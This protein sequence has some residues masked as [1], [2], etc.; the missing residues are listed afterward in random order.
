MNLLV[1]YIV[2]E[3]RRMLIDQVVM[4]LVGELSAEKV[5]WMLFGMVITLLILELR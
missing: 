2:Y 4:A 1:E 3:L 5:R